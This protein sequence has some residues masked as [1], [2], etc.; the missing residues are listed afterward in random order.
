MYELHQTSLW[1]DL[2]FLSEENTRLELI[3]MKHMY[4]MVNE[5]KFPFSRR[6]PL[7]TQ[8][9]KLSASPPNTASVSELHPE[10]PL[11]LNAYQTCSLSSTGHLPPESLAFDIYFSESRSEEA[12]D[13]DQLQFKHNHRA[14][15]FSAWSRSICVCLMF[16]PPPLLPPLLGVQITTWGRGLEGL[17]L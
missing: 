14:L 9:S 15:Y 8:S 13:S 5:Q 7:L 11:S 4:L 17:T 16:R 3:W 1:K 2:V 6:F 10:P 12:K